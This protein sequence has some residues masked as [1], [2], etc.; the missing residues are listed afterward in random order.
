MSKTL[1]R[2][3]SSTMQEVREAR[4]KLHELTKDMTVEQRQKFFA[5]ERK[6]FEELAKSIQNQEDF[7]G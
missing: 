1:E 6:R 2:T 7:A 5:G 3:E 4:A